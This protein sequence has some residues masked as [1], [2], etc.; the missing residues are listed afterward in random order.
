MIFEEM[1]KAENKKAFIE[2]KSLSL[3]MNDQRLR[4]ISDY[5]FSDRIDSDLDRL[6]AGDYYM[7]RPKLVMLRKAGSN[8]RRKVYSFAI[9]DRSLLQYMVY[10][11]MEKYDERYSPNLYSFRKENNQL[12]LFRSIIRND[13][14]R[15][16]YIIKADIHSYGETINTDILDVKL[17]EW[18][19]DEPEFHRFIMWL[20]TRNEYYH[21]GV[22]EK[23]FTSV[24]SGNPLTSFLENLFLAELDETL[25]QR[26]LIYVRY[27]DDICVM[28]EDKESAEAN[29]A[30]LK[31]IVE[32]KLGLTLNEEKTGLIMPYEEYDLLG[33]KFGKDLV[34][35]SDNTYEKITVRMKHRA[36]RLLRGISK[37]YFDKEEALRRMAAYINRQFYATGE[38][39]ENLGFAYRVMTIINSTERLKLLDQLSQESLRIVG[40]GRKTNAKYR[41]RYSDMKKLGYRSLIH[42]YYKRYEEGG[43][44]R[45]LEKTDIGK[46]SV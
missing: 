40:S 4:E 14:Q 3:S 35:I 32:N 30:L 37:G 20:V 17:K 2:K 31:D 18:L 34:E 5:F 22:L 33:Y 45:P 7:E 36:N 16:H 44:F 23:G 11:V 28:C 26:S 39:A 21:N 41:I 46:K 25:S 24:M 8:R 38:Q 9:D 10:M 12:Y 6:I 15:E 1:K 19:K 43:L 29:L 13:P 42:E 27:T